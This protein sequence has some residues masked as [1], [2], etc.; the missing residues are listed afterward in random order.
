MH[1]KTYMYIHNCN[2]YALFCKSLYAFFFLTHNYLLNIYNVSNQEKLGKIS[3]ETIDPYFF[4]GMFD[5][6]IQLLTHKY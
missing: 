5:V 3:S 2:Y 6:K 1:E 4:F